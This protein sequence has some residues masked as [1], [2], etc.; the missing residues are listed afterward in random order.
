MARNQAKD[1][2]RGL[3]RREENIE[4]Y[5]NILAI[6]YGVETD[7]SAADFQEVSRALMSLPLEQREVVSMKCFDEMTFA[8]IGKVLNISPN[9]AA[10][11]YRYGLQKLRGK[12]RGFGYGK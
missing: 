8:D 3:P 7:V 9:T 5:E 11:R 1:F 2:L 4:D 12:L 6:R 10:S